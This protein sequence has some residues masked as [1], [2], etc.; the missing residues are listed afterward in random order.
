M[1]WLQGARNFLTSELQQVPTAPLHGLSTSHRVAITHTM[2]STTVENK[3]EPKDVEGVDVK[4]GTNI[5]VIGIV[6]GIL[7][8]ATIVSRRRA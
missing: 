8:V 2:S 6:V 7:V 3:N 1:S 4:G 5:K